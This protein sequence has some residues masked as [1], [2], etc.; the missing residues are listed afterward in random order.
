M[1]CPRKAQ[2]SCR[3][4]LPLKPRL[5][6]VWTDRGKDGG[7]GGEDRPAS[8]G[9]DP[10]GGDSSCIDVVRSRSASCSRCPSLEG[11]RAC[12]SWPRTPS[13]PLLRSALLRK[14]ILIY[15]ARPSRPSSRRR[16]PRP[17]QHRR[18]CSSACQASERP[19]RRLSSFPPP[20]QMGIPRTPWRSHPNRFL[21]PHPRSERH[22]PNPLR[23]AWS[24]FQSSQ[25]PFRFRFRPSRSLRFPARAGRQSL[26]RPRFPSRQLAPQPQPQPRATHTRS[27]HPCPWSK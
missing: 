2:A 20:G 24:L 23:P 17:N 25:F 22:Q 4:C 5:G 21:W 13:R 27:H 6:N 11:S 10:R 9:K 16:F 15:P 1:P 3:R 14:S 26:R 8:R 12:S 19:P 7:N 18:L